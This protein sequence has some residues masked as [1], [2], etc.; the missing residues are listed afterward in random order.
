M[1]L[2]E[3]KC[4]F[5][6]C[7]VSFSQHHICGGIGEGDCNWRFVGIYGSAK[8]EEKYRTWDLIRYINTQSDLP[9]LFSGDFNEILSNEEKVGGVERVRRDM[10]SLISGSFG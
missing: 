7:I 4:K 8:K 10:L 5:F 3:G 1:S 2:L 9:L 6:P